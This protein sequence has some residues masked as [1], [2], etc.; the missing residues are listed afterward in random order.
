MKRFT[1]IIT[2]LVTAALLSAGAFTADAQA[3][4]SKKI[5][6]QQRQKEQQIKETNR[7]IKANAAATEQ[8]LNQLSLLDGEI[9]VCNG[10]IRVLRQRVDSLNRVIKGVGDSVAALDNRLTVLSDKYATALQSMQRRRS[11]MSELAFLFSSDSF[12]QAYK[13]YRSLQQFSRWRQRKADEI[14]E[15]RAELE[16]KRSEL[17]KL[18]SASSAVLASLNRE[19]NSLT[20]KQKETER[21]VAQLKKESGNL[22]QI[23]ARRQKEA[24]A[25]DKELDRVIAEELRRKQEEE[26]RQAAEQKKREE[27]E[28]QRRLAAA[29]A[30]KESDVPVNGA[31]KP[32]Q[33]P[34]AENKA[35]QKNELPAPPDVKAETI[36]LTGSFES[37]KGKLPFPVT[38]N[39]TI[40]KRF[41]RQRHPKLPKVETNNSGIDI[42]TSQGAHVRTVFDG[43]VSQI[44]RLNGY[45]NVVVVRHGEYVTVYANLADL[46]VHKGDKVK[47]GQEIGRVYVDKADSNRSVLHFEVRR[48]TEKRNPEEWVKC[49]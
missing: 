14:V 35:P 12:V 40:V 15:L 27:E 41:G 1:R 4:S 32:V 19:R 25:L 17:E 24:A 47:A 42:E 45:N 23:M 46:F 21:L 44:F 30:A 20:A 8:K 43:E 39:Y 3:R 26:A 38:G 37:N 11:S 29:N 10:K 13:R 7:K 33:Q 49:K 48:E 34:V 22:R 28:R 9:D 5:R 31:D 36:K 18:K 6:Q 2:L 16:S